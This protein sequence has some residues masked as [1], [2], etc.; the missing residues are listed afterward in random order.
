MA[1]RRVGGVTDPAMRFIAPTVM[2]DV[3]M[4]DKVMS[5]EIFGPV[6]P[7]LDY[8]ELGEVYDVIDR[9]PQHPLACY[10]FSESR[11]VQDELTANVQF[12]GG[13][14]NNCFMHVANSYLP[15]GGVGQS[16]IG[17]YHGFKGVERFSHQKSLLK[18]PTRLDLPLAYAPYG[19]KLRWV[20]RFLN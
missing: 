20:R 13:C 16:G 8:E 7:V 4:D 3:T 2:R 10:V 17:A 12:G 5:E 11:A 19:E 18:T 9:L 1:D 6:L 15:F 14:V